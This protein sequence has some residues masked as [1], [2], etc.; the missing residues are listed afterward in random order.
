MLSCLLEQVSPAACLGAGQ[1]PPASPEPQCPGPPPALPAPG[2]PPGPAAPRGRRWDCW[3]TAAAARWRCKGGRGSEG[4]HRSAAGKGSHLAGV[5]AAA[6]KQA[7]SAC[8]CISH[9]CA[10]DV[11]TLGVI[12]DVSSLREPLLARPAGEAGRPGGG[13][14]AAGGGGGRAGRWQLCSASAAQL[15]LRPP[16]WRLEQSQGDAPEQRCHGPGRRRGWTGWQV[17]ERGTWLLL[18]RS[19]SASLTEPTRNTPQEWDC[20]REEEGNL[21]LTVTGALRHQPFAPTAL[22]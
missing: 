3:C 10:Q 18:A 22:I 9:K 13:W 4:W 17:A 20:A 19:Q 16:S 11:A 5:H 1:H 6:S 2:C 8:A 7:D 12:H 21:I 14:L 15:T